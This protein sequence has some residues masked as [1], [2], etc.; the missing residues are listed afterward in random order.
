MAVLQ[1]GKAIYPFWGDL[2][3]IDTG[4]HHLSLQNTSEA[5][6]TAILP[7]STRLPSIV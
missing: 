1:K 6:C 4:F 7:G 2:T 3:N 5:I